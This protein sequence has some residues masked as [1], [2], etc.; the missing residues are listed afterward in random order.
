MNNMVENIINSVKNNIVNNNL[1]KKNDKV[2][3]AVSGG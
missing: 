3:V 2:I 1:I